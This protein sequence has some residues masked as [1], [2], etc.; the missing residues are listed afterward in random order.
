MA[1]YMIFGLKSVLLVVILNAPKVYLK[2][3]RSNVNCTVLMAPVLDTLKNVITFLI[4]PMEAMNSTVP[5]IHQTVFNVRTKQVA[6]HLAKNVMVSMTVMTDLMRKDVQ[7]AMVII[8]FN[9]KMGH[10]SQETKNVIG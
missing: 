4:A 3:K 10:V 1:K 6:F 8:N 9:V 7:A 2:G 5:A